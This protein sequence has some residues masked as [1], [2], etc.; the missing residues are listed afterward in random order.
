MARPYLSGCPIQSFS[1][2]SANIASKN[3][4]NRGRGGGRGNTQSF[5]RNNRGRG[6]G[7]S[8]MGNGYMAAFLDDTP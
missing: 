7:R 3:S 5:G 1:A 4:F 6:R 2:P 8:N